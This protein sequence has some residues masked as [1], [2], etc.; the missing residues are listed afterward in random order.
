MGHGTPLFRPAET[1][2]R[3]AGCLG[4]CWGCR[5]GGREG[6]YF[7]LSKEVPAVSLCFE[8][9]HLFCAHTGCR[10]TKYCAL[11]EFSL[12]SGPVLRPIYCIWIL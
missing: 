1:Q 8:I 7:L 3:P 11:G 6:T 2:V 12:F 9:K 5:E 4:T 10:A